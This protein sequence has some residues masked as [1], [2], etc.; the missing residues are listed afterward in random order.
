MSFCYII[1]IRDE[2][3]YRHSNHNNDVCY[4]YS[5]RQRLAGSLSSL[6]LNLFY[7]NFKTLC[8]ALFNSL[9]VISPN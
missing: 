8:D 9:N 7:D 4:Y 1:F 2:D 3:S 6:M 5:D